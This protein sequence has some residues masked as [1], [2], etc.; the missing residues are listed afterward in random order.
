MC[1]SRILVQRLVPLLAPVFDFRPYVLAGWKRISVQ[2]LEAPGILAPAAFTS[3]TTPA[4]IN[5]TNALH[6]GWIAGA[7]AAERRTTDLKQLV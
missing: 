4:P 6:G 7:A 5:L 1:A 3:E 2:I